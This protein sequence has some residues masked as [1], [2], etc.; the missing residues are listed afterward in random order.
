MACETV[1]PATFT[2]SINAKGVIRPVRPT[3]TRI[4]SNFVT[5]SSGAYLYAI[6]HLGAREVNPSL[7]CIS[8]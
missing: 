6:A 7:F 8:T 4:S 5:T 3:L 1:E 2:G